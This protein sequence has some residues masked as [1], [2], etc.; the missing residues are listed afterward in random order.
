MCVIFFFYIISLLNFSTISVFKT[1]SCSEAIVI[2]HGIWKHAVYFWGKN[3][4]VWTSEPQN[5]V[6]HATGKDRFTV[7]TGT[8]E[9]NSFGLCP[10]VVFVAC[11]VWIV[12]FALEWKK[13]WVL[14]CQTCSRQPNG[15]GWRGCMFGDVVIEHWS[16][17]TLQFS[18]SLTRQSLCCN[19]LL[20]RG[21]IM[22]F[23][24]IKL[25][26]LNYERITLPGRICFWILDSLTELINL[27]NFIPYR[28]VCIQQDKRIYLTVVYFGQKG[29]QDVKLSLQKMSRSV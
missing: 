15:H 17:T 12:S 5:N 18:T 3:V 26:P 23:G 16:M 10:A 25:T 8:A 20:G 6:Q 24:D 19:Q 4:L 2:M 13:A 21:C 11:S 27:L 28:E 22:A 9:S 14:F 1:R 7:L 29:L